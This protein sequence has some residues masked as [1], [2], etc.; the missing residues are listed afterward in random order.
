MDECWLDA[1]LSSEMFI[2][3]RSRDHLREHA[4]QQGRQLC[5]DTMLVF[6]YF[7]HRWEFS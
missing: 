7:L 3:Q 5:V 1:V 2:P 6:D 4:V